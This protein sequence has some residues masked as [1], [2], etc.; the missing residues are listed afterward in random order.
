MKVAFVAIGDPHDRSIWAG[1]PHY[2][3]REMSRRLPDLHV[4]DT[5]R[6]DAV[7]LGL[8][9]ITRRIG[10]D[11]AREPIFTR[12]YASL[13]QR[14]L[15]HIDPDVV[16]SIGASNKLADTQSSWPIVH[17]SD[18]LFETITSYYRKYH[19]ISDRS[20]RLGNRLQQR[21]IDRCNAILL[22]S[23]WAKDSAEE[24]YSVESGLISVVPI[25]AN[26]DVDPGVEILN[27]KKDKLRLLF[28]GIAWDRKGGPLLL[29]V[30]RHIRA[31]VQDAE[32]HIAGC[33]PPEAQGLP[34]VLVHGYLKKAD[35]AQRAVLERLYRDA[36]IFA[37]LSLEEA[38]GL[39]YCE[40]AAYGLPAA[41]L[42]TGG[43]S[44]I[45]KDERTG[46]LFDPN[47]DPRIIAK[48][49]VDLWFAPHQ[50]DAMRAAAR[51]EFESRLNWSIWGDAVERELRAATR[52]G[53]GESDLD[54]RPAQQSGIC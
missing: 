21:L 23:D 46:L 4:I 24:F 27:S 16:L 34:G 22:M 3:L 45:V 9:R 13:V 5:R 51:H 52:R 32:L 7:L 30:F 38:F 35:P 33:S 36:S 29:E 12:L 54:P 37:M 26:L 18:A 28:V 14:A 42:R 19:R 20:R 41:A 31:V 1:T 43:V 47:E 53:A 15:R 2:A 10:W 6:I 8:N 39:V 25:G 40:A 11:I 50:Y 49:I 44:T 17:V 48:R